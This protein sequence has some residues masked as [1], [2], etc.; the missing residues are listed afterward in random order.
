MS[1]PDEYTDN[2]K[3]NLICI[4]PSVSAKLKKNTLPSDTVYNAMMLNSSLSNKLFSYHLYL[5][6]QAAVQEAKDAA[7]ATAGGLHGGT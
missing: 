2:L 5:E 3:S 6:E 1:T 7:T 4:F